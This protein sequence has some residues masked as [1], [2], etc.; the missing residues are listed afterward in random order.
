MSSDPRL[1]K[2]LISCFIFGACVAAAN[3]VLDVSFSRLG[4][5]TTTNALNDLIIGAAAALLAW[6]WVSLETSRNPLSASKEKAVAAAIHAD[7]KRIALG[8]HDSMCQV[9]IDL[10]LDSRRARLLVE[11]DGQGFLPEI[12]P[13]SLGLTSMQDRT[14]ALGSVCTIHSEPGQGTEV[15]ASIPIPLATN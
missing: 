8:L 15:H 5:S 3:Y 14:R 1:E 13:E 7:R 12:H 11:D 4:V 6:S 2:R 9:Q 10:F